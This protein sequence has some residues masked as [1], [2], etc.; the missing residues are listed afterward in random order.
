MRGDAITKSGAV[1]VGGLGL[2]GLLAGCQPPNYD[3]GSA[4]VGDGRVALSWTLNGITLTPDSCLKER[5]SSINLLVISDY[6]PNLSI[7]FVNVT[8]GLDRFSVTMAPTG[9]VRIFVDAVSDLGGGKTCRRFSGQA[10]TYATGQFPATP[11]PVP[12]RAVTGCP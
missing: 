1:W 10:S 12:L 4:A 9:P 7:E 11:V 3:Q 6:D 8:C 2:L 5:I